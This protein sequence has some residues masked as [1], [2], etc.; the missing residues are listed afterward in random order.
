MPFD[1]L[2]RIEGSFGRKFSRHK[3]DTTVIAQVANGDE[4]DQCTEYVEIDL[5]IEFRHGP[6]RMRTV[7]FAVLDKDG[8]PWD[9][10][11]GIRVATPSRRVTD[12]GNGS[13]KQAT[14]RSPWTSD[15]P[16]L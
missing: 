2:E 4:A 15:T 3:L 12:P 9:F 5:A 6:V 1:T 14:R 10:F 11:I 16:V 7:K 8:T 13:D